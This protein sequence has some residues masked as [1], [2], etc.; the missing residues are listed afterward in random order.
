[1]PALI[2]HASTPRGA[3]HRLVQR[4]RMR[5]SQA[6][7][8]P[9]AAAC[10]YN[11]GPENPHFPAASAQCVQL[12]VKLRA[13][14]RPLE[15][16]VIVFSGYRVPGMF[17]GQLAGRV[18]MLTSGSLDDVRMFA[19]PHAGDMEPLVNRLARKIG[20]EFGVD[21]TDPG[22]TSA[23]DVIG[24]SMGG[25]LGRLS[26]SRSRPRS[27]GVP[28]IN[29]RRLF[30]IASPHTGANLADRIHIDRAASD[31][32]RGSAFL[33]RLAE[34]NR[35]DDFEL[36]PYA[37]LNDITV[38]PENCAPE[39][40]HPIW[41]RGTRRFAHTTI[42]MHPAIALD[43]ALRLRGEKPLGAPAPLPTT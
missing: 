22:Q 23:V 36:I 43:I 11:M 42:S 30:T 37:T 25:I 39:G 21:P 4:C 32:R 40:A 29:I 7:C 8:W 35:I 33:S 9:F 17:S 20:A 18:A 16:P 6:L 3:V 2:P 5:G 15:R 28:R 26:A 31:M 19:Y 34:W 13:D 41:I 14:P 12:A 24:I 38:G 27:A 10:Q 1:M